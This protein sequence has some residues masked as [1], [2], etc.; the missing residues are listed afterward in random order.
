MGYQTF[1][2]YIEAPQSCCARSG[3]LHLLASTCHGESH[4]IWRATRSRRYSFTSVITACTSTNVFS[5]QQQPWYRF[6][7]VMRLARLRLLGRKKARCVYW[8]YQTGQRLMPDRQRFLQDL[9][10][11]AERGSQGTQRERRTSAVNTNN[12][13]VLRQRWAMA[14]HDRLRQWPHVMWPSPDIHTYTVADFKTTRTWPMPT[15][16]PSTYSWPTTIGRY[17][18]VFQTIHPSCRYVRQYHKLR[19]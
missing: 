16:S 5:K 4:P 19:L 6:S 8:R 7:T 12:S 13:V 15:I 18:I 10:K 17:W 2:T 3:P 11:C 1:R 9:F 14:A